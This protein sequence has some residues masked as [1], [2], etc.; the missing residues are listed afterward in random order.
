MIFLFLLLFVFAFLAG[1]FDLPE[2]YVGIVFGLFILTYLYLALYPILFGKKVDKI[3]RALK[4]F[5]NPVYKFLYYMIQDEDSTAEKYLKKIRSPQRAYICKIMW[6]S[7]Q[8]RFTEAMEVIPYIKE[9]KY[10]WYLT[11]GLALELDDFASYKENK[12]RIKDDMLLFYLEVEEV[13]KNG[14][15]KGA[16]EML[17]KKNPS[18]RGMKLLTTVQQ[19]KDLEKKLNNN[20]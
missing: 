10:K 14:E 9:G 7:K 16:I 20:L 6:L 4:K 2:V 19:K 3:I 15:L 5:K 17:N 11:A 1:L 18:L 8:D 13:A 12:Q